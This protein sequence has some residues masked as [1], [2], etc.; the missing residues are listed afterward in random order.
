MSIIDMS[1]ARVLPTAKVS[2]PANDLPVPEQTPL[3]RQ[4]FDII[5]ATMPDGMPADHIGAIETFQMQGM[6]IALEYVANQL[7]AQQHPAVVELRTQ[8]VQ[9]QIK[10][11][12]AARTAELDA[13]IDA[14]DI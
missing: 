3:V 14:D 10:R 12:E 4:L 9:E 8:L 5:N 6:G 7:G 2:L 11:L 1:Q 13:R